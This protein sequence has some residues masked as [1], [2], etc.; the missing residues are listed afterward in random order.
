L[1]RGAE[2]GD[3]EIHVTVIHLADLPDVDF[4][5]AALERLSADQATL[6]SA[7]VSHEEAAGQFRSYLKAQVLDRLDAAYRF[8]VLPFLVEREFSQIW[9]AAQ[10]QVEIPA[11]DKGRASADLRAIAERRFR[12]G[13]VVAEMA[14]RNAIH[15]AEGAELEDKV[16]DHF[17]GQARVQDRTV[18]EQELRDMMQA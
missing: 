17:V 16:I 1:K 12:L 13:W 6:E 5:E 15:A 4:T 18:S 2:S 11:G 14:R 8:S 7:G 10:S 9:K 3:V